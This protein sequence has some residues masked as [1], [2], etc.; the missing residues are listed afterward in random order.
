MTTKERLQYSPECS[1]TQRQAVQSSCKNPLASSS[2]STSW[3][4]VSNTT[5]LGKKP[6]V[7]LRNQ[8][9]RGGFLADDQYSMRS[10]SYRVQSTNHSNKKFVL[11]TPPNK[12][13]NKQILQCNNTQIRNS[14]YKVLQ[15]MILRFRCSTILW[16]VAGGDFRVSGCSIGHGSGVADSVVNTLGFVHCTRAYIVRIAYNVHFTKVPHFTYL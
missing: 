7:P 1:N 16:L 3:P 12:Q 6:L 9:R 10:V 15:T 4:H 11:K 8:S 13:T 2:D 14:S 5:F